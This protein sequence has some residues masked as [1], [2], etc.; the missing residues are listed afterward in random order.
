MLDRINPMLVCK[1]QRWIMEIQ[2]W[3]PMIQCW[4][5]LDYWNPMLVWHWI[6]VIQCWFYIEFRSI[7]QNPTNNP[8]CWIDVGLMLDFVGFQSN[9]IQ[10]VG[11]SLDCNPTKSNIN[12]TT[13]QQQSNMLDCL[14]DFVGL[15]L[16]RVGLFVGLCWIDRNPMQN[17]HW[18]ASIHCQTNI[19]FQ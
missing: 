5:A 3:I 12:Q 9:A 16:D 6:A 4:F 11:F 15:M 17:Q 13:I 19:G 18:I 2:G 10:H 7:Q 14:L 1:I 8:T